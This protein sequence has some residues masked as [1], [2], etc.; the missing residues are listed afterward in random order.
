MFWRRLDRAD[1]LRG[2]LTHQISSTR[3]QV[4]PSLLYVKRNTDKLSEL[5]AGAL[6]EVQILNASSRAIRYHKS[7][8]ELL[9]L[10]SEIE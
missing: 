8:T 10:R 9:D 2:G 6:S 1:V 7:S 3:R 4:T 5:A